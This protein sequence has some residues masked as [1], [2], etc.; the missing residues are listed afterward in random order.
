LDNWDDFR[1]LL[2]LYRDQT[3]S[4]AAQSLGTNI[5]TVSRRIERLNESLG[6]PTFK[7]AGNGWQLTET[8][9]RFIPLA[10]RLEAALETDR[11]NR[12]SRDGVTADL[13][14]AAPPMVFT[15]ILIP[16]MQQLMRAHPGLSLNLINRINAQGLGEADIMIRYERPEQG[17]L[18]TRRLGEINYR[19]YRSTLCAEPVEGWIS[20]GRKYQNTPQGEYGRQ[21]FGTESRISAEL[22]EHIFRLMHQTGLYA[23]IPDWLAAAE[24]GLEPVLEDVEPMTLDVWVA[25]HDTRRQDVAIGVTVDWLVQSFRRSELELSA[26]GGAES[27]AAARA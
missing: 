8:G 2:A 7:K 4:A 26:E 19:P 22:Y 13:T 3:M 20:I 24:P 14:L 11:N 27:G 1:F 12:S 21:V 15:G 23:I 5:T 6:A 10:E 9:R 25:Y 18:I 16:H 17:R